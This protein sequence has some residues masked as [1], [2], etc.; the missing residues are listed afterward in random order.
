MFEERRA[1][2]EANRAF[3]SG[4]GVTRYRMQQKVFAIGDDF[5]IDDEAGDHVYKVDAK[6]LRARR[7]YHLEDTGGHRVATVQGKPLH[8]KESMAIEDGEGHHVATVKKAI[9]SPVRDRWRITRENGEDLTVQGNVLDHEYTV[10][11][12]GRKVAE[13][14]KRWFRLRDTYGVDIGP[15]EDTPTLLAATVAIDAM[16]HPGD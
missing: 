10:E 4:E 5:W 15:G 1:R 12:D 16:A 13:V 7:T 9:V 8:I 14:S 3:D 2:K 11:L 6:V